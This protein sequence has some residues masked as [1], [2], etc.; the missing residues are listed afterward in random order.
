[1]LAWGFKNPKILIWRESGFG[2]GTFPRPQHEVCLV[3]SRGRSTWGIRN[4]G[5]V[6]DWK[7]VYEGGAR[8]HS[9]KPDGFY[10][11]VTQASPG[12]YLELFSRSARLGWDTYG[13]EALHGTEAVA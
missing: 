6:H 11:L 13:D 2:L 9:A 1:V 10:D 3:A 8:K 4:A 7:V 5:S 12:P